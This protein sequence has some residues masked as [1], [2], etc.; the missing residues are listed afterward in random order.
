MNSPTA[1]FPEGFPRMSIHATDLTRRRAP[2]GQAAVTDVTRAP[3][4]FVVVHSLTTLAGVSLNQDFNNLPKTLSYGGTDRMRVSSQSLVR[5]AREY[6]RTDGTHTGRDALS[7]RRLPEAVAQHLVDNHDIDPADAVPAAALVVAATGLGINLAEPGKTRAMTYVPDDTARQ[8]SMLVTANWDDTAGPRAQMEDLIGEAIA[9]AAAPR[10]S[11]SGS[12]K[13][14]PN[15]ADSLPGRL[16]DAARA[17]LS[18]GTVEELALFGRM[19]AEVPNSHLTSAAHVAHGIGVDPLQMFDDDFTALDDFQDGGI[20]TQTAI[21]GQQY[22]VSGTLYRQAALDRRQLRENLARS[23]EDDNTVE[24]LA[25]RAEQRWTHAITHS[26]PATRR[27]R[28]GSRP[29][30]TLTVI[31][32]CDEALTAAPAFETPVP[33][34]AGTQAAALLAVY[35]H[36][37]GLRGGAA[38]WQSPDGT[39][40]PPLPD[41]LTV[42]GH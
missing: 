1:P 21:V 8:L 41:I 13:T 6:M 23:G 35:L 26:L 12:R 28:T 34:P 15:P 30:P 14:P 38:L 36:D 39:T 32:S 16:I 17:A 42:R 24:E 10:G 3:G 25:Q 11:S 27:S 40:P 31:A 7:T 18:P 5:A 29:R 37:A 20:F 9:A 33:P 2:A 4:P 19:L 22:L